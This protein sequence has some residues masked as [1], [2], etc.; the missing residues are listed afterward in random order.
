MIIISPNVKIDNIIFMRKILEIYLSLADKFLEI[1]L[2][3]SVLMPKS[4]KMPKIPVIESAI[5]HMPNILAP[6]YLAAYIVMKNVN[7]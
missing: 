3:M 1:S 5:D 4:A 7:I 2:T 6:K